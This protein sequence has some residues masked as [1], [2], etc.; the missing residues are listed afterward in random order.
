MPCDA[1]N[2]GDYQESAKCRIRETGQHRHTAAASEQRHG[3]TLAGAGNRKRGKRQLLRADHGQRMDT[4][5]A[6][7]ASGSDPQ[8]RPWEKSTGPK[9]EEG[10]ARSAMRGFKGGHRAMMRELARVLRQQREGLTRMGKSA[11]GGAGGRNGH[12][13]SKI[14]MNL[15]ET[16]KLARHYQAHRPGSCASV[17]RSPMQCHEIGRHRNDCDGAGCRAVAGAAAAVVDCAIGC[18][19]A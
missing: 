16:G 6:G 8:W 4:E 9:S 12:E 15:A 17:D 19:C 7:T 5:T 14:L 2:T 18:H 10:K 3:G 1:R 11:I 13:W